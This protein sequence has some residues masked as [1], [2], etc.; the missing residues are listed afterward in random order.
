MSPDNDAINNATIT[1]DNASSAAEA[2]WG[3]GRLVRLVSEETRASFHRGWEAWRAA[4]ASRDAARVQSVVAKMCQA[5]AYMDREATAAGHAPLSPVVWEARMP[6][7]RVLAVV[8]TMEEAHAV[9][10]ENRAIVVWTMD[11]LARVLPRLE[12]VNAI[13]AEFPGATVDRVVQH[14]PSFAQ[15]WA[16]SSDMMDLLHDGASA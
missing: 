2:K 9:Q 1:L 13:K 11:E 10:R 4:V 6:D 16:T 3:V 12:L 14:G 15:D 5:W 8:R 7:G